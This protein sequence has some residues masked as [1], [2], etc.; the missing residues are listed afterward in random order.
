M[1]VQNNEFETRIEQIPKKLKK[2]KKKKKKKA[3]CH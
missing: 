3:I 1:F 2:K